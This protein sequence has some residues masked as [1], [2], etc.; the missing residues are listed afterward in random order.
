MPTPLMWGSMGIVP[1]GNLSFT[2]RSHDCQ[3]VEIWLG[4][5]C[6]PV[7]RKKFL[8]QGVPYSILEI[9]KAT[10][11]EYAVTA[12][13]TG[14]SPMMSM[15]SPG[16]DNRVGGTLAN[17]PSAAVRQDWSRAAAPWPFE[18]RAE[19]FDRLAPLKPR[20][21]EAATHPASAPRAPR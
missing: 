21:R 4:H 18:G 2:Q 8:R 19:G 15:P 6:E 7:A 20:V 14:G 5:S 12:V 13:R 10:L 17:G 3:Q 9:G 16:H 1:L 11:S